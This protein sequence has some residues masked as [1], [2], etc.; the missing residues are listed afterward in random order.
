MKIE[1]RNLAILA[2]VLVPLVGISQSPKLDSAW[3]P[4]KQFAGT[5]SGTGGGQPGTGTYQRSYQFVL[6]N[7]FIE[8]KN[9]SSYP[10][11]QQHPSGEVH[12]DIGYLFYDKSRKTFLL[13]QMHV[14]GFANDYVLESIA[15]DGKTMVFSSENIVNIP[16]GWR[17]RETYRFNGANELEET[18]ELAAPGKPFELYSKVQ[19][20]KQSP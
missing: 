15:A 7:N 9:R 5:W 12:E 18:F 14:E 3:L 2:M 16:K 10:P 1:F 6:N 8:I 4:M 17:A 20:K 11:S 13:R 19:L